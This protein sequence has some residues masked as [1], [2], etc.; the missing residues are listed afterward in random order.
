MPAFEGPGDFLDALGR[1]RIVGRRAFIGC[2]LLSTWAKV[3]W[4]LRLGKR[5]AK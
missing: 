2:H 3:R 4:R 1:G 5:V